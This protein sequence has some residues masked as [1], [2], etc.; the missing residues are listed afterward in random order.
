MSLFDNLGAKN[1]QAANP[2]QVLTQLKQN[3]A[4]F[5]S[6][7]GF[8]VPQGMNNPQQIINHLMQSGQVSQSKYNQVLQMLKRR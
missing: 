2:M 8:N 6:K 7:A 4:D 1:Q 3:P 5:I